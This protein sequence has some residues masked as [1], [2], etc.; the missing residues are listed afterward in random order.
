MKKTYIQPAIKAKDLNS[1]SILAASATEI[2]TTESSTGTT[3]G[4]TT[5]GGISHGTHE[6][7]SKGNTNL[8]SED[9]DE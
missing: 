5:Y 8:W 7:D 2:G 9:E 4:T 1:V 6:V 3:S